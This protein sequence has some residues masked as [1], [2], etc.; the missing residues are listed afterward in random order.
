MH[1]LGTPR[2]MQKDPQYGDV[3]AEVSEYLRERAA[4]AQSQGIAKDKII[5]DP[6]IGFGKTVEHNL[7]LLRHI[8]SLAAL[9]YPLLVG[10]SR[11]S[12]IGHITQGDVADRVE[13]SIAVAV[14][15]A[16]HGA[17][18]V[19]VHDVRATRRAIDMAM[20]IRDAE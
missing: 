2:T 11:K 18:I 3:V 7:S 16:I 1:M 12:F 10:A 9:G 14:W 20:A 17:Q 19:R 15:S 8:P 6:G 5:L 4:W 13:G